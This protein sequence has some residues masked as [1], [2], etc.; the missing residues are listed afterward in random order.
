M[1]QTKEEMTL[2]KFAFCGAEGFSKMIAYL[3]EL[4]EKENWTQGNEVNGVLRKYLFGTFKQCYNQ[5]KISYTQDGQYACFNTGLLTANGQD[6]VALFIRNDF[7]KEDAQK[8]KL[9]GFFDAT[10]REFMSKFEKT[11][12]L[13]TYNENGDF[14]KFYFHPEYDINISS[15]H[16]LDDNWDRIHDVIPFPKNIVKTL[17]TGVIEE[18][19]KRIQRN[20][21]LVVPQFYR[22]E[23]MYL[24]PLD[25]PLSENKKVTMALAVELTNSK[26]YRANTI[27]TKE[28]AYE[29]ARLL[30]KPESNWLI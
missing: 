18:T 10:E 14:G 17:L 30:M 5:D 7:E 24:V 2:N 28:M 8:W 3:A 20:M 9:Q 12:E 22:G 29:K 27:F 16:I 4:A 19:K 26:Q 25:I 21:R 11:P 23:I 1:S 6:I 13:A 15:D